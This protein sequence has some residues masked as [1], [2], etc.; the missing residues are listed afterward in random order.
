[1]N[2]TG[3]V[4]ALAVAA[5]IGIVFAV[6]PQ[7]DLTLARLFY[8]PATHSFVLGDQDWVTDARN[9]AFYFV[10][11]FAVVAAGALVGKLLIPRARML[12]PGSAAIFLLLTL[13]LGPGLLANTILKDHWG[14]GRP[15]DVIAVGSIP[16]TPWWDF[17]APCE[18]NCSFVAGEPSGAFWTLAPAA[19]T[20]PQWRLLAYGGALGFGA[21]VGVLRMAAGGHFFTD[22]VFAGVFMFL[23]IWLVHGLIYRWPATRISEGAVERPLAR[24][25]QAIRDCLAAAARRLS[26]RREEPF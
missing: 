17:R 2:R 18:G 3:L 19:L 20:P 7:L 13:A 12:I 10:M 23:L 11:V 26:A 1:M 16:F 22:V 14:R 5:S 21:A 9:A 8:D 24:A 6:A 15:I 25:G 4:F